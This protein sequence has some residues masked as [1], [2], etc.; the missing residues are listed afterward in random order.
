MRIITGGRTYR[1]FAAILGR[2]LSLL[3]SW[4]KKI[5]Q[6]RTNI[7]NQIESLSK[8]SVCIK[9]LIE[10]DDVLVLEVFSVVI[11]RA[12]TFEISN[13]MLGNMK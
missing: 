6:R 7:I 2:A 9:L 5:G 13:M 12:F 10:R 11:S 4:I 8:I 3:W 1:N